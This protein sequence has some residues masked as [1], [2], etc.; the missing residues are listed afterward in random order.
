M[1][2]CCIFVLQLTYMLGILYIRYVFY[3]PVCYVFYIYIYP[4]YFMYVSSHGVISIM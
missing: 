2:T 1:H 4:M 3:I